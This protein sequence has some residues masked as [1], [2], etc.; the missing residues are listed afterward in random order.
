[1]MFRRRTRGD[2]GAGEDGGAE[3]TGRGHERAGTRGDLCLVKWWF[4]GRFRIRRR[5]RGM[6]KRFSSRRKRRWRS[7]RNGRR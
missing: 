5:N 3:E 6:R 2:S 7:R 4:R 1:M